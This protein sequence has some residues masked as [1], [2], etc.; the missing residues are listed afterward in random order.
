MADE[1]KTRTFTEGEAYAL[2]DQAVARETAE[3]TSKIEELTAANTALGTQVDT[4]ETEK[5]QAI[6]RAEAAEKALE[7]Y[8]AEV[9][10]REAAAARKDVRLAE[11]AEANP[12]LDLKDAKRVERIVAMKDEEYAGYLDDMKAVGA[13]TGSAPGGAPNPGAPPRESAALTPTPTPG[14]SPKASVSGVFSAARATRE[15]N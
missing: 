7:D 6:S 14:D 3:A 10:E 4:L 15:G 11:V 13:A 1:P 2:V 5:A 8:K 9:A 12:H